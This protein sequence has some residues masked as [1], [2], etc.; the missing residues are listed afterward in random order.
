MLP[1]AARNGAAAL[2]T[3]RAQAAIAI[4]IAGTQ[5]AE[6]PPPTW[7]RLYAAGHCAA[8]VEPNGVSPV[9]VQALE[10]R[11]PGEPALRPRGPRKSLICLQVVRECRADQAA[12]SLRFAYGPH[13]LTCGKLP[14]ARDL[15]ATKCHR[16]VCRM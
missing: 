10:K 11:A 8:A 2:R 5:P 3:R 9:Y 4:R 7:V 14:Q 6:Q 1:R 15:T 13:C 12:V 16:A